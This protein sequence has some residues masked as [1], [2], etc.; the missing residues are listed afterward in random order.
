MRNVFDVLNLVSSEEACMDFSEFEAKACMKRVKRKNKQ[1][2]NKHGNKWK[3]AVACIASVFVISGGVVYAY[4]EGLL[5]KLFHRN[6]G[7]HDEMETYCD[8]A[9][10]EQEY[11]GDVVV[12]TDAKTELIF[13]IKKAVTTGNMV[14]VV[15][16]ITYPNFDAKQ[17]DEGYY[18]RGGTLYYE[19]QQLQM[20]QSFLLGKEVGLKENQYM[21]DAIYS[22]PDGMKLHEGDNLSIVF[23]GL[24][25]VN[26][27]TVLIEEAQWTVEF[28]LQE[29]RYAGQMLDCRESSK[30][31]QG[32][33]DTRMLKFTTSADYAF[34]GNI[35]LKMKDGSYIGGLDL[36][37]GGSQT[38]DKAKQQIMF[39]V[40]FGCPIDVSQVETVVI[41]Q[42]NLPLAD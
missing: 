28:L 40:L 33:L 14:N 36:E 29:N 13:E 35:K 19:N 10:I 15:Y 17:Y 23:D 25:G 26:S 20:E 16:V 4:S 34:P 39:S 21:C 12:T 2:C 7:L 3:I 31:L 18:M 1:S 32:T 37:T 30:I 27:D 11:K 9:Y 6:N 38:Y 41:G 22:I 5:D 24:K 42:D 8:D